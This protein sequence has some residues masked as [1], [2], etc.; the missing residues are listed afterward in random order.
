M[1]TKQRKIENSKLYPTDNYDLH[2]I[3]KKTSRNK[4]KETLLGA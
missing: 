1:R 4:N 3:L 2:C